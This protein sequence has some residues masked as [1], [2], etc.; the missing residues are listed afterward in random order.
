VAGSPQIDGGVAR[1]HLPDGG[2]G[3]GGEDEEE[4]EEENEDKFHGFSL[5]G[6]HSTGEISPIRQKENSS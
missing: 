6:Q 1:F 4:V 5:S 3:E 2:R